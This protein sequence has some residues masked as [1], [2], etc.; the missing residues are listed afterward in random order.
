LLPPK[1]ALL[2]GTPGSSIDYEAK[3]LIIKTL[4]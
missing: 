3:L 1:C 2:L 4:G